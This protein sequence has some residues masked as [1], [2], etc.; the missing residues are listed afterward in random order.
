MKSKPKAIE[1]IDQYIAQFSDSEQKVLQEV[2]KC[3][4]S[5][6]PE[7]TE[8]IKYQM[9]T[10]C[11]NGNLIHFAM[12]K[13]H[14]GVYPTPSAIVEFAKELEP[15]AT[16]KG[17]IQFPLA[18]KIPFTLIKKMTKFRVSEMAQKAAAK[19]KPKSSPS[20]LKPHSSSLTSHHGK[21]ARRTKPSK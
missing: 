15:Y 8:A 2:R 19:K 7:A 13:E 10:F 3:I 18:K 9:P 14:L 16:S 17:A 6:A 11:Q 20:S 1:T 4:Q 21:T 12:C 5:A